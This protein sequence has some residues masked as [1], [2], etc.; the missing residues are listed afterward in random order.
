MKIKGNDFGLDGPLK[1]EI[2]VYPPPSTVTAQKRLTHHRV[3][4]QHS[5]P[6]LSDIPR[7]VDQRL[8]H[9]LP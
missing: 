9:G 8:A 6:T 3:R 2:E 4:Q 7:R 5:L 1:I